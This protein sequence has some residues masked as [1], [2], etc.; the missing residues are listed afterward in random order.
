MHV[1]INGSHLKEFKSRTR[2]GYIVGYTHQSNTY[3]V[4]LP[5]L[6]KVCETSDVIIAPHHEATNVLERANEKVEMFLDA[7]N[8]ET[9]E[10][11]ERS[12]P[13]GTLNVSKQ[14]KTSTPR[15]HEQII[16]KNGRPYSTEEDPANYFH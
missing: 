11:N 10:T 13:P 7:Q 1:L 6:D 3:R 14:P 12:D 4:Y 16:G 15:E 2:P 8:I 9:H 5:S